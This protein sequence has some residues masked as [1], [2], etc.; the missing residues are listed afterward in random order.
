MKNVY[1]NQSFFEYYQNTRSLEV[2]ANNLIENPIM[3]S[4]LP[5]VAGKTILDLGCGDGNMDAYFLQ[6][7][8]KSILGIDISQKMI[9]E[10]KRNYQNPNLDFRVLQM[11]DI[12][13]I[14]Q[15]FDI[16]YSS[17]AFHY[18]EDMD[19]LLSDIQ[20]LLN[21]NG[22]LIFSQESPL[23]TSVVIDD[24]NMKNKMD[25]NGKKYFLLSDYCNE[26]VRNNYWSGIQV[27]KY[28]RTYITMFK[29]ITKNNFEIIDW[30]DSYASEEAIR[31]CEKYKHQKDKP[32]FTFYKLRKK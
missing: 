24:P 7:G 6:K 31:L 1:D 12:S 27:T 25:I 14:N 2:N 8:A 11:E 22:I 23:S 16:V 10:A 13:S 9:A 30:V 3:K 18:V 17:L 4:M 29:L 32:Y 21:E 20:N 15:K 28:H 5:D 19:K 26:G